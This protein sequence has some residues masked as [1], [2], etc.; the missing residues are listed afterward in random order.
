MLPNHKPERSTIDGLDWYDINGT[1]ILVDEKHKKIFV[2]ADGGR[3]GGVWVRAD[4]LASHARLVQA[5]GPEVANEI[6][7][8]IL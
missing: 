4:S 1:K 5:V 8:V 6:L 3:H 2:Q 7:A